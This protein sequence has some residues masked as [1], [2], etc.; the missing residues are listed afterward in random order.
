[1]WSSLL[2]CAGSLVRFYSILRAGCFYCVMECAV[3]GG[4]LQAWARRM[5]RRGCLFAGQR[6]GVADNSILPFHVQTPCEVRL[7]C[8]LC[9]QNPDVPGFAVC[10]DF[11]V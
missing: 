7:A 8:R 6:G 3:C 2:K 4:H 5:A 11:L 1:M 9:H 10:A